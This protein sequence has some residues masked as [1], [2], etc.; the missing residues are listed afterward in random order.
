[1]RNTAASSLTY[2]LSP[3]GPL[4][5]LTQPQ[6]DDDG[7]HSTTHERFELGLEGPLPAACH[8]HPNFNCSILTPFALLYL[9]IWEGWDILGREGFSRMPAL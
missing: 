9:C 6:T 3:L 5:S 8:T 4:P 1:M 7:E 2:N